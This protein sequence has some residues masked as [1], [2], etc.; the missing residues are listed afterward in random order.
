MIDVG[1]AV[2]VGV[3]MGVEGLGLLVWVWFCYHGC[4]FGFAMGLGLGLPPR[5][6]GTV[7]CFFFFFFFFFF[8]VDGRLWV[9][10]GGGVKC[11]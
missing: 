7:G 4:A 6:M 8:G 5:V 10:G 2:D 3:A 1:G 9:A 11:V